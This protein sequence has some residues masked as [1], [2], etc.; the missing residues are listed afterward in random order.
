MMDARAA[1]RHAFASMGSTIE[2][3]LVGRSR[4]DAEEAFSLAERLAGEWERT[5]SRFRAGSELSRLNAAAGS[6]V[7]VSDLLY[8][9]VDAA[10]AAAIRTG[11][12]FDP[13]VL[14]SLTALGYD[15]DFREIRDVG[16]AARVR[17][18]PGVAGIVLDP[19]ARTVAL[20]AGVAIDLGGIAKGLYAD[21]LATRLSGWPGG[22][23]SA[24][25]DLRAWGVSPDGERWAVGIED[26]A[27]PDKDL[28]T[29]LV[30]GRGVAT[31]GTNRRSWRRAGRAVHHL[32]DPRTGEPAEAGLRAV[33]VI[34]P[35]ATY[36]EIA[37]LALFVGG[38]AAADAGG[39]R[40]L[41]SL[42]IMVDQDGRILEIEGTAE[43][44]NARSYASI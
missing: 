34:A 28:A 38:P 14:P 32:I 7:P 39:I 2:I 8:V 4:A 16:G 18:S 10:I 3:V 19:S 13:T 24:G 41:Y 22:A 36:A 1:H 23:V 26:P 25:G 17:P 11:G 9:A 12:L 27:R 43:S 42:A 30:G 20:P 5:F 31:S 6:P 40:S 15:R 35:A 21:V 44:T 33:T 29:V 37:S